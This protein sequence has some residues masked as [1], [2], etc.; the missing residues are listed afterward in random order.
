MNDALT[1]NRLVLDGAGIGIISCYLCAPEI[2]VGRLVHLLPEWTAPPVGVS[3]VFPSKR[4]LA[5]VVRVF[6]EFM[7][8]ANLPGLH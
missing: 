2:A 8:D 5:P 7:K 6:V 1:I 3:M 4:E